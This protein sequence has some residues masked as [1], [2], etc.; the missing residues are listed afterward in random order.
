MTT[1]GRATIVV[2]THNRRVQLLNT[3][4]ALEKLPGNW[5][6]I[7]M[8]NGSRDGT[9]AAVSL[10]FP[11]V[12]LIRARRNLG[13]AGRNIAAAYVHTPYIAFCDDDTQWDPGSLQRAVDVMDDG[14][15]IAVLNACVHVGP[16]RLMD[17]TC[18]AMAKSPLARGQL[19]GPRL[20]GFMAGACVM[21]TR[22][23]YDAGGYWPPL[24][25][26]GEEELMALDLAERGWSMVYME[27]VVTRHFP[28]KLR[29]SPLR[30][31]LLVRN[32]IWVAWMRRP[33][34][35]AWRETWRQLARAKARR[36]LFLSTIDALTGLPRALRSRR[37]VSPQVEAMRRLLDQTP[38]EAVAAPAVSGVP[39]HSNH[40]W[41][42]A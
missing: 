14:P 32:A 36:T 38:K 25:I 37:V 3:L 26:G 29:D 9:A 5:P 34:K 33:A 30:H 17:P 15:A 35:A 22:A 10:R 2:L 23:F 4:A 11:S 40:S 13:A 24:F 41:P 1:E 19:P 42:R 16:M 12:M 6:I 20:L 8:D 31:R 28:S 7:V 27:D 21:R 39:R 18:Q